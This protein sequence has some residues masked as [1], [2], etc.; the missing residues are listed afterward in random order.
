MFQ[1]SILVP[2]RQST[3]ARRSDTSTR[4]S[5]VSGLRFKSSISLDGFVAGWNRILKTQSGSV[6]DRR[7]SFGLIPYVMAAHTRAVS[8]SR[9]R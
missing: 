2:S 4:S 9:R 6:A 5:R 1:M 7:V 8:S 3:G